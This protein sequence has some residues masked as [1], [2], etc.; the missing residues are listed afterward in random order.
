MIRYLFSVCL[1]LLASAELQAGNRALLIG[2]TSYEQSAFDLSGIDKDLVTMRRFAALLGYEE[3]QIRTV[4]GSDVTLS[5][6]NS[7]FSNFLTNGVG[8]ND[9]V[10]IYYSGHG[11]QLRDE[12][13][14][15]SDGRDEALTLHNLALEHNGY[16]GVL[17]DDQLQVMLKEIPSRNIML[18]VDACHSGTVTRS[19]TTTVNLVTQAYGDTYE[20]KA[21]PYRGTATRSMGNVGKAIESGSL[22]GLIALSAAQDD[23]QAL[24]T[25]LGSTFTLSLFTA[26]QQLHGE[27]TPEDL[28]AISKSIIKEKI[29]PESMFTPNISGDP[30]LAIR[31]FKATN[32][33]D[34]DDIYWQQLES[35]AQR[36]PDLEISGLQNRYIADEEITLT[37]ELPFDGYL[38]IVLVDDEDAPVVLFPNSYVQD[39]FLSKG[40]HKVPASTDYG[41]YAQEPWGKNMLVALHSKQA[42]DLTSNN[43][44]LDT[45]GISVFPFIPPSPVDMANLLEHFEKPDVTTHSAAAVYFE[46]C[47]SDQSCWQ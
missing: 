37:V 21:L 4:T 3:N 11:V 26:L 31:P 12:N 6:I 43:L 30:A 41:W 27:A 13:D 7:E 38:N 15:E 42:L 28:I 39:N 17:T 45:D 19:L 14:D 32:A 10:L 34:R 35:I 2:A 24:A 18:I 46:T 1:L 23:E 36:S 5:N 33:S 20:V 47:Q 40:T 25:T 8:S 29:D 44:N 22:D 16:S 9:S